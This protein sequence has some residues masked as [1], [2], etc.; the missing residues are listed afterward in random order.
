MPGCHIA[1]CLLLVAAV[2]GVQHTSMPV[3]AIRGRALWAS[4][5]TIFFSVIVA[6]QALLGASESA[7]GRQLKRFLLMERVES[8]LDI[9]A[10]RR[11]HDAAGLCMSTIELVHDLF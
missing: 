7:A 10:V 9:G 3:K 5:R 8:I 4:G 6:L 2:R 11:E 1:Q